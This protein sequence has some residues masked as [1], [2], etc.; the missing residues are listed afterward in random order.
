MMF[1]L[2]NENSRNIP[3]S[4]IDCKL[5]DGMGIISSERSVLVMASDRTS[6]K[7]SDHFSS[8]FFFQYCFL[9][10]L[11]IFIFF[12]CLY[13]KVCFVTESW[14]HPIG[15]NYCYLL[16]LIYLLHIM[17]FIPR[18]LWIHDLHWPSIRHQYKIDGLTQLVKV[19]S[20]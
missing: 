12:F 11:E 10:H 9:K 15:I 3:L 2:F 20:A 1:Y 13:I 14:V 16:Q 4:K 7:Y 8:P 19:P 5:K 6:Q 18:S 17:Q